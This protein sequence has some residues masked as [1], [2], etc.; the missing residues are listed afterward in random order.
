MNKIIFM[1]LML[2]SMIALILEKSSCFEIIV[3]GIIFLIYLELQKN[4]R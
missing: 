2:M 1:L 3:V 4:K